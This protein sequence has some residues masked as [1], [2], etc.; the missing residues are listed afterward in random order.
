M[1][2]ITPATVIGDPLLLGPYFSGDSWNVWRAILKAAYGEPLDDV[3]LALFH[4]VAGNRAPPTRQ[5]KEL[6]VIAGRRSGKDSMASAIATVAS[7]ADYSKHL[8]PGEKAVVMCLAVDRTQA[9]VVSRYIAGYFQ[10]VDLLAP[11]KAR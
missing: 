11:L 1:N 4:T 3:E 7:I 2:T 8:R 10:H 5:V 6:W 9:R